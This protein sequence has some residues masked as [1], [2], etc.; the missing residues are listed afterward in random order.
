MGEPVTYLDFTYDHDRNWL[1]IASRFDSLADDEDARQSLLMFLSPD[2]DF[3]TKSLD[4]MLVTSAASHGDALWA[5]GQFGEVWTFPR[6]QQKP[7]MGRLPDSG[8]RGLGPP[9]RI[10]L[11][12]DVPYVCGYAGQF[13]TLAGDRWVHMDDGLREPQA[14]VDSLDLE[15]VHGTGKD[16]LFVV[17]SHGT[18]AHWDGNAW[19]RHPLLTSAYLAGVRS[20]SKTQVVAVGD[21]GVFV[22]RKG[23][24]WVVE[25]VSGFEETIF[26]DIEAFQGKLYIAAVGSLL[27][28]VGSDWRPVDTGLEEPP[29][30]IRLTTGGG[31]LWAMGAKRI[32][33]F[34]GTTW[35]AHPDPD[36]D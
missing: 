8:P 29:E 23:S 33:S 6:G 20:L 32:H 24:N 28:R 2:G 30:F 35:M 4:G 15:S 1:E 12:A 13:Y 5:V 21:A 31:R 18:L 9:A 19:A 14:R 7:I 11:I 17:G 10:R 36:N 25:Q 22:E 27:V 3:S 16:D 34:D 26:S